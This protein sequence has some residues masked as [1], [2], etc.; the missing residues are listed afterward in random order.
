MKNGI[1]SIAAALTFFAASAANPVVIAHRG[2]WN[3][4]GSAQNSIRSLVKADSLKCDATEFDVWMTADSVLVVNHDA[5]YN[6]ID[7]EHSPASVVTAQKLPNG[8]NLP[9]LEEFLTVA[10]DLSPML[11]CEIKSHD[12]RS[13]EKAAIKRTVDMINRFGLQ[14]RT[15]Y[16]MFSKNGI[17]DLIKLVPEGTVVQYPR[18]DYLPEQA[19]MMGIGCIDYSIKVLRKNPEW[20][21][22]AHDLGLK[23]GIWTITEPDDMRWSIDQGVD[24]ITCNDPATLMEMLAKAPA[25]PRKPKVIA[26]RGYWDTPGSAKNSIRALVKADSIGCYGSEFDVWMT[27]DSVLVINHDATV[28]GVDIEHSPAAL[29]TA[30]AIGNGET[31]ATLE[32]FLETARNL[33]VRLICEIKSHDSNSTERAAIRRTLDMMRAFGLEDRVEYVTFSKNGLLELI[34]QVPAGTPVQYPAGDYL[35]EQLHHFGG[36][37]LNYRCRTLR[38]HPEMIKRCH[39]L[40]IAV[41]VWKITSDDDLRWCLEHGVDYITSDSPEQHLRILSRL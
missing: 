41:K 27:A 10:K 32:E 38:K 17:L 34:K 35:P 4:Q 15:T 23:V 2:V 30:Q 39:D 6:G 33:D 40:G 20:I 37:G 13:T 28:N 16:V 14:D 7:I 22:R 11:V 36:T 26:H 24:Y 21:A 8:E 31:V 12:S 3:E 19:A 29:V 5:T 9:T 18:G 1:L 25:T